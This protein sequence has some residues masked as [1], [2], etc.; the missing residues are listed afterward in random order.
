MVCFH[1]CHLVIPFNFLCRLWAKTWKRR[2]PSSL[3]SVRSSTLRTSPRSSYR[4][5]RCGCSTY[6]WR[7]PSCRTRYTALQKPPSCWLLMRC[8]LDMVTTKKGCT[9][10]DSWPTIGCFLKGEQTQVE[11][12]YRCWYI[13]HLM[14]FDLSF[15]IFL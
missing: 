10:P 2:T 7:T 1:F 11:F 14:D 5:L 9:I 4:I 12:Y 3:N 8:K 13:K 6:R 15:H